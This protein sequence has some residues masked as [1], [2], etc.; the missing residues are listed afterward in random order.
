L[1]GRTA[2]VVNAAGPLGRWTIEAL[3]GVVER[4]LA[5]APA[6]ALLDTLGNVELIE[7]PGDAEET[8]DALLRHPLAAGGE[9]DLLV[10]CPLGDGDAPAERALRSAWQAAKHGQRV[11]AARGGGIFVAQARAPGKA[12]GAADRAATL[13]GTRLLTNAA[14][15]DVMKAGLAPRVNRLVV[16]DGAAEGSVRGTLLALC[17]ART[18][19]MSGAEIAV[20]RSATDRLASDRLDGRTIL[21][22]GATSGIGRATA[23][24]VGRLG[25][26]VAVGG[27]KLHLAEETAAMVRAAG[28]GASIVRLD[29]TDPEA[30]SAAIDGVVA[31]RGA[32]HGLVNNAGEARNRPIADLEVGDLDWLLGIN[33]TGAR[34]GTER[35]LAVMAAAGD[36]AIVNVASVAG[37]RAGYGGSAY[38][39]SK[40]ALIGMTLAVAERAR[41]AGVRI[42]A[43]Q[44]GLIWSDSVADS[45]GKET[46][47]AFRQMIEPRTPLGRV[48]TPE[49]VAETIAFLLTDAAGGITGQAITAS[50]GLELAFP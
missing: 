8:W 10:H 41:D 19:F 18:R 25:G 30:W 26:H 3:A 44:P 12:K 20:G 38:G 47:D 45:M 5:V 15:L 29:V 42:N 35:A 23:I 32:L 37:I 16:H 2:I 43:F 6:D 14:L 40:A 17:D 24:A 49:E 22:T 39:G 34:L 4:V 50:G 11:M 28:G 13:G 1:S 21:I 36:G 48:G 7:G 27:R 46:A 33:F 31:E 9:V